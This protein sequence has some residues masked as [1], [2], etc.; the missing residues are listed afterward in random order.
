[1]FPLRYK[2][3]NSGR[4]INANGIVPSRSFLRRFNR[5][6]SIAAENAGRIPVSLLFC[7]CTLA[8]VG[9]KYW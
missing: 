1:L 5:L 3:S 7:N 6:S 8:V 4:P 2:Y 9:M